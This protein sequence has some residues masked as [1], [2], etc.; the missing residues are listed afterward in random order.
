MRESS[1]QRFARIQAAGL[2]S[3]FNDT[4]SKRKQVAH[5]KDEKAAEERAPYTW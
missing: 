3:E 1:G 2:E 5:S 4:V